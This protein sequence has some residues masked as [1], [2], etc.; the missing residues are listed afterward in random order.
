[1]RYVI[2]SAEGSLLSHFEMEGS[3]EHIEVDG[4]G[5][6][7]FVTRPMIFPVFDAARNSE[8][9]KFDQKSDAEATMV[10]AHLKD[11]DAFKDC[12]VVAVE[13]DRS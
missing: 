10:H 6:K 5:K 7:G 1:M 4:D 2:K 11:A 3:K 8:A 13:T 9:A 12:T